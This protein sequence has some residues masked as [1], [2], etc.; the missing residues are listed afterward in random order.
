M[1]RLPARQL[2]AALV[3]VVMG[4][5]ARHFGMPWWEATIVVFLITLAILAAI[6]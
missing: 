6:E 4:L 2:G 5:G 1:P 3:A